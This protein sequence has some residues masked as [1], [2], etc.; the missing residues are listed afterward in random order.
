MGLC[1]QIWVGN[2]EWTEQICACFF[3]G[4]GCWAR[5]IAAVWMGGRPVEV[6]QEVADEYQWEEFSSRA[7][8]TVPAFLGKVATFCVL[9][10][11][12]K[13]RMKMLFLCP[14]L[15]CLLEP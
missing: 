6:C 5:V 3:F 12:C 2:Q 13:I 7:K 10:P 11:T 14:W 15:L 4:F 9:I 1:K 8:E